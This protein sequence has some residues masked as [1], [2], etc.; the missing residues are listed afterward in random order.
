MVE[1][2]KHGMT[3]TCGRCKSVLRY[4]P[5]DIK[6]RT[7]QGGYRDVDWERADDVVCYIACPVCNNHVTVPRDQEKVQQ[8][9]RGADEDHYY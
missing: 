9:L 2:L 7:T 4:A 3:C 1:V 8:H 6:A 5:A